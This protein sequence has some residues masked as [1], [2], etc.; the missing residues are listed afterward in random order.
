MTKKK[1]TIVLTLAL[2]V[3]VGIILIF[4]FLLD[5]GSRN[6][7]ESTYTVTF[8]SNG[9]TF[10]ESVTVKEG[11]KV[12]TPEVP[13]R[14]GFVFVEWQL[15]NKAYNFDAP[16]KGDLTLVANYKEEST[17]PPEPVDPKPPVETKTFVVTFTTGTDEVIKSQTI[18]EGALVT[19][20]TNPKRTGYVF[21]GWYNGDN[22]FDFKTKITSD[23]ELTAKWEVE[24][25]KYTVKFDSDGGSTISAIKVEEGK[26]ATKPTNPTKTGFKFTGWTLDGKSYDFATPVNKN[27]TLTAKWEAKQK[28]TV[29]FMN[30]TTTVK[31]KTVYEGDKLGTLPSVSKSGYTFKGWYNDSTRYTAST[32]IKLAKGENNLTLTAK[33]AKVESVYTYSVSKVDDFSTDRYITIYENGKAVSISKFDEIQYTTGTLL[34]DTK[35]SGKFVVG[36]ADLKYLDSTG[37]IKVK[38]ADGSVVTARKR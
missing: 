8:D 30:G 10:I 18:K 25:P 7:Q 1:K 6:N 26:T 23:I 35:E 9:G 28:Y 4:A 22:R 16:V 32:V 14:E 24:K 12:T 34:S 13:F 36:D 21:A 27:I 17:T 11:E 15:D 37:N 2:A 29:T 3:V 31:T 5:N 19:K 20:P 38:L 33:W